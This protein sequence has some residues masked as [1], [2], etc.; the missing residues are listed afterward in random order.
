[1]HVI[2]IGFPIITGAYAVSTQNM[3]PLENVPDI[4]WI[5][6]HPWHCSDYNDVV[7]CQRSENYYLVNMLSGAGLFVPC[8]LFDGCLH[9]MNLSVCPS[10]RTA[11][12]QISR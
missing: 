4:C 6:P 3:N 7:P 10:N 1:M 8:G 5:A 2:A 11:L 12:A 9:G